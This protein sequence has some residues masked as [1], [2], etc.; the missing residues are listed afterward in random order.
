MSDI[1]GIGLPEEK[2]ETTEREEIPQKIMTEYSKNN[3]RYQIK[4]L[5]K[6]PE[7][8]KTIYLIQRDKEKNYSRFI[9]NYTI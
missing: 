4:D 5:L 2:K 1:H 8:G 7:R 3:N 9:R 6:Q